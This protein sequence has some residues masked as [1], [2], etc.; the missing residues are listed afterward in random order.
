MLVLSILKTPAVFFCIGEID[1]DYC[2]MEGPTTD[3]KFT[4]KQPENSKR[5]NSQMAIRGVCQCPYCTSEFKVRYCLITGSRFE[6]KV[7]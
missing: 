4:E 7:K 2:L 6:K 5:G 3:N 1:D